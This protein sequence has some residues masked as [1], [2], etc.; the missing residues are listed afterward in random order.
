[1][2]APLPPTPLPGRFAAIFFALTIA[3]APVAEIAWSLHRDER[4]G[5]LDTAS[6]LFHRTDARRVAIEDSLL[7]ASI[8]TQ[9]VLPHYQQWITRLLGAG[10]R[11]VAVARDGW[12]FLREDLDAAYGPEVFAARHGAEAALAAIVD[13]RDQ[14]RE[15]EVELLIVPVCGKEVADPERLSA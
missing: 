8:V 13:F 7:D 3:I 15:R 6:D 5:V 2:A 10:N 14:L 12:L 9:V 11:K 1:M 4:P